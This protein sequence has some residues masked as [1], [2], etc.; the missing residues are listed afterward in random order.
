MASLP[1]KTILTVTTLGVFLTL[2]AVVPSLANYKTLDWNDAQRVLDFIPRATTLN[3]VADEADR[4]NPAS[5][6]SAA[7]MG[8]LLDPQNNLD[9]FYAALRRVEMK[10]PDAVVRILHYGDSPTT[11]DLITADA[12]SSLQRLFGDAGHGYY[13]I[14]KPWAWYGHRGLESEADGWKTDPAN[15]SEVRD[16]LYG[17]GGVSFRGHTGSW[18]RIRLREPGH[19]RVEVSFLRQP[20]GGAFGVWA[21]GA[22]LGTVDT[23]G[24]KIQ[25]G[26]A[27]F[28]LRPSTT[29]LEIK[30]TS[31]DARLFGVYFE[32]PGPGIIYSSLGLNGAYVAVPA[33]MFNGAHWIEALR[34]YQ[35][36]LV[37]VN[38]GTNESVY[39]AFVDQSMVKEVKEVVRRVREAMP[40]ISVLLMSPMDR[41]QRGTGGE[42]ATVPV[43]PRLVSLQE[44]AAKDL[45]CGFFNTYQAMGGSGT[46]AKWY[47][48]EPRLVGGDFIHPMPAGARIVGNLLETALLDGYNRYKL[49]LMQPKLA[50]AA[51]PER[52]R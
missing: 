7:A 4:L 27:S 31:G 12:R 14:A 13:L 35:P 22:L 3:P 51:P 46:M 9:H 8:R 30:I 19:T 2:P 37:I 1:L 21:D 32:K 50:K 36:D 38:Y 11:A 49:R 44:G 28:P 33:R 20:Y 34:H 41:A 47:Q 17:L 52:K 45:G 26:F 25:P 42:I 16:G 43:M 18:S 15:Q 5:R 40:G 23:S 24:T 48:A 29:R 10:E 39:P 6:A